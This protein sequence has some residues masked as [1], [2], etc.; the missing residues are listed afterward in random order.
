MDVS[1]VNIVVHFIIYGV[2][3]VVLQQLY[4]K[5]ILAL[6][7]RR[8]SLTVGRT[9]QGKDL[10]LKLENMKAE[11]SERIDSVKEELYEKKK[12][13]LG[14][15]RSECDQKLV[16]LKRSNDEQLKSQVQKLESEIETVREKIPSIGES[17]AQEVVEAITKS[18]VVKL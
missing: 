17:L 13:A 14:A 7:R 2:I 10:R 12:E 1:L 8:E 4:F 15:V 3:L 6:I 18:R 9:E 5:P 16:A 11:Y